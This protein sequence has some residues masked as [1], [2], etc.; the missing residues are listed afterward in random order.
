MWPM[1]SVIDEWDTKE[2]REAEL[3]RKR[4]MDNEEW[5][6]RNIGVLG[7]HNIIENL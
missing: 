1:L 3:V 7:V 5:D 4:K 6:E 2:K